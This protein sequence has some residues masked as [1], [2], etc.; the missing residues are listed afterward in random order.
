MLDIKF[1]TENPELVKENI[2]KKF[3]DHK[4]PMVDEVIALN[5]TRKEVISRADA[6]KAERNK[7]SKENGMN[8]AKLKSAATDEEKA[9]IQAVINANNEAV[10][11]KADEIA[12]NDEKINEVEARIREI[13][14]AIPNIIDPSV[15][16]GE[17][18]SC[19]VEIERFG[20]PVVPDYE[21]PYHSDIMAKFN[22]IDLEPAGRVAGN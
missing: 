8:F 14:L 7:I 5:Q 1:V 20:E 3:Q 9:E 17:D 19:N 16:I 2:R 13:M 18:D 21:I 10:K 15:P 22:G 12:A 11:A 6:L 4:I